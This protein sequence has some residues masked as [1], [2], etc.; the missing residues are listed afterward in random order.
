MNAEFLAALKNTFKPSQ[1][2]TDSDSCAAYAAD[3]SSYHQMP[4]AV[5]FAQSHDEI[6]AIIAICNDY[7]VPLTVRGGGSATTGAA[8]PV[9]NGIILSLELMNKIIKIEPANRLMIVEAG[10]TNQA[11]QQ[12]AAKYGLFWAPDPGSAAYCTVGGNIAC[13]A[14]GPRTLKYGSTRENILGLKGII[15]TGATIQ[16]GV[17][18]TKSAVG[19]D[20]TRLLIGSEGT[21]AIISEATLKLIPK[22]ESIATLQAIYSNIHDCA[23][24]IAK[25]MTQ[26][27]MP[28]VLEFLDEKAIQL[29]CQYGNFDFPK[30]AK[31][32]LI[33]EIDNLKNAL[34]IACEKIKLAAK[35]SG[36]ISIQAGLDQET[37]EKLWAARR[38]LSPAL[39]QVAPKKINEDVVVPV[40]N[41][42][43]FMQQIE[44]LSQEY[45]LQIINFGH[46]GNGNIH[47]NLMIDPND[48]VQR[49]NAE[50]CLERIFNLVL[51]LNGS[52]SGEH[53]IGID[54]KRFLAKQID[55][56]SLHLMHQI[57][58]IFDP[59]NILNPGK[60][61]PD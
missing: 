24:A 61:L 18:T 32:L 53:G 16:T 54:K 2:L 7:H 28:S 6:Q 41:I 5:I 35:N 9:A 56:V 20:L 22:P 39:K 4:I 3:N 50:V 42:P 44:L 25:I 21:L 55:S 15:G 48:S 27:V 13:N 59:K 34:P 17:Y 33:I 51:Q 29:L 23:D 30:H 14:G 1:I 11:V 57:K 10:V 26:P 38:S 19:Y 36:L 58:K 40:G 37:I 46:G 47:V 12:E 49:Q 31:A 8:T 45:S 52:I 43:N 60:I